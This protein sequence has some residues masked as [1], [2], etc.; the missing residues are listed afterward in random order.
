MKNKGEREGRKMIKRIDKDMI[1]ID[2]TRIK[3]PQRLENDPEGFIGLQ[4][5]QVLENGKWEGFV[6]M[7]NSQAGFDRRVKQFKEFAR[8]A[9]REKNKPGT[10]EQVQV[11]Y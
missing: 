1:Q 9:E 5:C 6:S 11:N 7:T 3:R 4:E 8:K 10:Q 2:S